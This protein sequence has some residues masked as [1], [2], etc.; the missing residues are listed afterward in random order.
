MLVPTKTLVLSHNAVSVKWQAYCET[1]LC[2]QDY[3][4]R[5]PEVTEETTLALVSH[6]ELLVH[7]RLYTSW[8]RVQGK[9]LTC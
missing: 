4:S 5:S 7:T 6:K 1:I 3:Q 9:E 8:E 2:S